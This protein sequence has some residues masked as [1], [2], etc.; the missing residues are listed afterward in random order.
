MLIGSTNPKT[1][2]CPLIVL[3]LRSAEQTVEGVVIVTE[4]GAVRATVVCPIRF[5][6]V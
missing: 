6:D 3:T 2:I 1:G 5:K 4:V